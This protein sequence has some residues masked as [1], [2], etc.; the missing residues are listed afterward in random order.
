M[1]V[2]SPTRRHNKHD[3]FGQSQVA[4]PEYRRADDLGDP[5]KDAGGPPESIVPPAPPNGEG[6]VSG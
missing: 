4:L 2:T 5:A 3:Q 6:L 1:E